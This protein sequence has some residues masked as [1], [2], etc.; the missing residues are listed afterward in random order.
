MS[1]SNER[2]GGAGVSDHARHPAALPPCRLGSANWAP[3][4]ATAAATASC[5]CWPCLAAA[6]VMVGS[7]AGGPLPVEVPVVADPRLSHLILWRTSDDW[8]V[9][10]PERWRR[11]QG[12]T[13]SSSRVKRMVAHR[14]IMA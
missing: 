8:S 13:S 9:M 6:V 11:R 1:W 5:C 14:A 4:T 2:V 3:A 12:I 7:A 10:S